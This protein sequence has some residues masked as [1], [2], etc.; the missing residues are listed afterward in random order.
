MGDILSFLRSR[1]TEI[2]S[3]HTL[4]LL[5][6]DWPGGAAVSALAERATGLFV[7][8]STACRFIAESHD[9]RT[10]LNILLRGDLVR[11]GFPNRFLF[12]HGNDPRGKKSHV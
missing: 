6:H 5:A 12:H 9:P 3:I 4:L 7:W 10:S 8:A 11:R 1:M 2:R